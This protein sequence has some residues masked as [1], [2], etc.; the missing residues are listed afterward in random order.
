MATLSWTVPAT[1]PC[2]T[3][4][5]SLLPST[6]ASTRSLTYD[7]ARCKDGDDLEDDHKV[8]C[9]ASSDICV[10][11]RAEEDGEEFYLRGCERS[12]SFGGAEDDCVSKEMFGLDFDA[13][14]CDTD[15]CNGAAGLDVKGAAVFVVL[16]GVLSQLAFSTVQ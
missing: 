10:V 16:V 5:S 7:D 2:S 8:S 4:Q 3:V 1:S 13:C 9:V 12:V 11:L 6:F 14:V 15:Y